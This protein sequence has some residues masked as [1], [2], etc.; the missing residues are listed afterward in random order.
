MDSRRQLKIASLIQEAFT[1]VLSKDVKG[2]Y[3]KAFVTVTKVTVTSDLTLARFYL[4]I[5]NA[6]D[7]DEVVRKFSE[8]KFELKRHL[9]EKLRHHLRRIPEMEF[10]RDDT[11]DQAYKIEEVFRKINA[12]NLE[13]EKLKTEIKPILPKA[14]AKAL[15]KNKKTTVRKK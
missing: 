7:A 2:F 3:G 9:A 15:P 12:E 6:E 14:K 5:F 13:I 10:F 8:H 1:E 4:S 11:L